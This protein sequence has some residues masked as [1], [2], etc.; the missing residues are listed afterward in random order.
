MA[1][2]KIVF[3]KGFKG[4]EHGRAEFAYRCVEGVKRNNNIKNSNYKSYVKK[5]L[6]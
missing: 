1:R 3:S 4:I 6:C 5:Y 2:D